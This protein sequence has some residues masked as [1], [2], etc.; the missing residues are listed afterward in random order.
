VLQTR[1]SSLP[2][3]VLLAAARCQS[4]G[5]AGGGLTGS[6]S[7]MVTGILAGQH[8]AR[9]DPCE[10]GKLAGEM[11]LIGVA[12]GLRDVDGTCAGR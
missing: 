9:P 6:E 11:R 8:L 3:G 2:P 12:E 5:V 4:A 10:R 7:A 1:A